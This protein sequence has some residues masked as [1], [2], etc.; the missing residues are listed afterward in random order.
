[1]LW[2]QVIR[3]S[4]AGVHEAFHVLGRRTHGP[5]AHYDRAVDASF[6]AAPFSS[7]GV[8]GSFGTGRKVMVRG[9][10]RAILS[11]D[12]SIDVVGEAETGRLAVQRARHHRPDVST[13]SSSAWS[14]CR[15]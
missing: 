12:D 3:D 4:S 5:K 14:S 8:D 7:E 10:L 2:S 9:G 1:M 11:S 6:I 15:V 13:A